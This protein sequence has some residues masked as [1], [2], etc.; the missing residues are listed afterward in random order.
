MYYEIEPS[1]K[2][3]SFLGLIVD[4]GLEITLLA[5]CPLDR[6]KIN[7]GIAGY[8][9]YIQCFFCPLV[10]ISSDTEETIKKSCLKD[11]DWVAFTRT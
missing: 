5:G 11:Q 4:L 1:L 6:G 7:R 9:V 3:G 10:Y 8:P 2:N